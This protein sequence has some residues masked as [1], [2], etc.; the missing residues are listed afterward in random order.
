MKSCTFFGHRDCPE[1]ICTRL[2]EE[3]EKLIKDRGVYQFYVG[4]QGMFDEHVR[5]ALRRLRLRYPHIRCTVVLAYHPD[6][7]EKYI[8]VDTLYPEAMEN[9]PLKY[10]IDRRN[11]WML[12]HADVVVCYVRHSFGGAAKYMQLARKKGK[13]V[14][15]LFV[16]PSYVH[17]NFTETY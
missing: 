9:T 6:N 7:K 10:A 12:E 15:N 2:F 14:R 1:E 16:H 11:R 8:N 17:E 4:Q 3:L 13:E 5:H